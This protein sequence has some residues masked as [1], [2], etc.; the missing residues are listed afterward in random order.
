[1][2][3]RQKYPP[4]DEPECPLHE[5]NPEDCDC[6]EAAAEDAAVARHEAEQDHEEWLSDQGYYDP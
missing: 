2:G 4:E 6:A 5:G 1:M 3:W